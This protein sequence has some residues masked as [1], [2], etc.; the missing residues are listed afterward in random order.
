[1]VL[2]PALGALFP[3]FVTSVAG[4]TFL[5]MT[6]E[7]AA[8]YPVSKKRA[9]W[10]AAAAALIASGII[11]FPLSFFAVSE[12]TQIASSF[13]DWEQISIPDLSSLPLTEEFSQ[14]LERVMDYN[15][16]G[17]VSAF[18]VEIPFLL[19]GI[20][21]LVFLCLT[22]KNRL[23]PWAADHYRNMH[24]SSE[25]S[26]NPAQAIRFGLFSGAIWIFAIGLFIALGFMIGFKFSWLIFVFAIAVQLLVQGMLFKGN[27]GKKE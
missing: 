12:T 24:F 21:I 11:L 15:N 23:K 26:E 17:L 6:Q 14:T 22:E 16:W 27:A 9:A 3:F 8:S 2:T 25:F 5:G 13:I 20:G 19:P 10:Y 1:M 18:A 4:F 7:S